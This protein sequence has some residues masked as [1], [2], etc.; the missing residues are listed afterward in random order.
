MRFAISFVFALVLCGTV[1]AAE[2]PQPID[3]TIRGRAVEQPVLKYQLLPSDA[4]LKP[5]NAAPILLR[6]PWEQVPWMNKEFPKLQEWATRPLN[7]PEWKASPC[8]LPDNFYSEMKRAAYR[9]D[10]SWEYPIHETQNPYWILLPDVQGLRMFLGY[11]LAARARFHLAH[12]E[13]DK[14][15]EVILVGLANSRHLAQ[16]P[17]YVNQLNAV[18]IQKLMLDQ[19][20][21]LIAQ[22]NSP[23]LYWA[24]STLP[25][26]LISIERAASFE[27]DMFTMTLPAVNDLDRPRDAETWRQMATQLATLLEELEDMPKPKPEKD[28]A[29]SVVRKTLNRWLSAGK[30]PLDPLV[31]YARAE[32]PELL[33]FSEGEVAAMSDDEAS[34]RWYVHKRLCNDQKL[35]AVLVLP[36]RQA[37][38]QLKELQ[39]EIESIQK[40]LG[41]APQRMS[42]LHP[43]NIY[44]SMRSAQRKIAALRIVEA[45]RHHLAM[46]GGKLP[47]SLDEITELPIPND[48]LTDEPFLWKVTGNTATLKGP[49]LP[50][51]IVK[52]GSNTDVDNALEYRLHVR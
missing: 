12:D 33:K 17:F 34:I 47:D 5:G 3:L 27:A 35:G 36:P 52:P 24:L 45:V 11:G 30:S 9:H 21:E 20:G 19:A 23:N 25:N 16:T 48:P 31:D 4:Q 38:P 46:H 50:K 51:E 26:S 14:A 1:P 28:S 7:A 22:P 41:A 49:P 8:V 29:A 43:L 15:R 18:A 39:H 40:K 44:I 32:L 6:L 2:E 42:F 13:M 37:W 10:A